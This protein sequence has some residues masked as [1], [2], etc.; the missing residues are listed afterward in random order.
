MIV[1]GVR[2]L[3][4]VAEGRHLVAR[5]GHADGHVIGVKSRRCPESVIIA[6]VGVL[7]IVGLKRDFLSVDARS[8][9]GELDDLRMLDI[10][11]NDD[12]NRMNLIQ[13]DL[14]AFVRSAYFHLGLVGI[15]V[16]LHHIGGGQPVGIAGLGGFQLHD[17]GFASQ[18]QNVAFDGRGAF[19]HLEAYGQPR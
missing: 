5:L 12:H 17:A 19:H 15:R 2:Y 9:F 10:S 4:T 1:D 6:V 13:I 18:S 8:D 14:G 3:K 16:A 11:G 7:G